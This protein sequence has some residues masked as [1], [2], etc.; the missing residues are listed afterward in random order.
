MGTFYV[1]LKERI[2]IHEAQLPWRNEHR[3]KCTSGIRPISHN[4]DAHLCRQRFKR[5]GERLH[6][7]IPQSGNSLLL[8]SSAFIPRQADHDQMTH[9]YR[10]PSSVLSSATQTCGGLRTKRGCGAPISIIV[11]ASCFSCKTLLGSSGSSQSQT[12]IFAF[13]TALQT[14]HSKS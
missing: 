3:P 5:A 1:G 13:L 10:R 4:R 9:T 7:H 2:L 8:P 12:E 6:R 11:S 14:A